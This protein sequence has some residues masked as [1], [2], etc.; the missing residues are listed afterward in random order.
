MRLVSR[1]TWVNSPVYGEIFVIEAKADKEDR[2]RLCCKVLVFMPVRLLSSKSV[3]N[4]NKY[5]VQM[6]M[7]CHYIKSYFACK[8]YREITDGDN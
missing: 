6:I 3:D 7:I 1:I 2:K 4:N 8:S 5:V